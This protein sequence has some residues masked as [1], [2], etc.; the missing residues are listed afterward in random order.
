MKTIC[1]KEE[2]YKRLKKAS[3]SGA[4][5]KNELILMAVLDEE[6]G[7]KGG[8]AVAGKFIELTNGNR[9]E[10]VC[11][12]PSVSY[13]A[14]HKLISPCLGRREFYFYSSNEYFIT[15]SVKEFNDYVRGKF[16]RTP[17]LEEFLKDP[18]TQA[19]KK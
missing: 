16:E 10:G 8:Y 19:P 11:L 17:N 15:T 18:L 1:G 7:W 4:L 9:R 2:I 12:L 3:K 6:H 5:K 14:T 13:S